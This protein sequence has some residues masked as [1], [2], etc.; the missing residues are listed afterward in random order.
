[1]T[2]VITHSARAA[3]AP[4]DEQP[5]RPDR[6]VDVGEFGSF[7]AE[8]TIMAGRPERRPVSQGERSPAE[9]AP[10]E[11]A[12]AQA[13][14]TEHA[15]PSTGAHQTLS[16]QHSLLSHVRA[17]LHLQPAGGAPRAD[18]AM[19]RTESLEAEP[20][21]ER[22][23]DRRG[24][25]RAERPVPASDGQ[26]A[27]LSIC[28][29]T[30]AMIG[31]CPDAAQPAP[32]DDAPDTPS[33][34]AGALPDPAAG[35]VSKSQE[36]PYPAAKVVLCETHFAPVAPR[37]STPEAFARELQRSAAEPATQGAAPEDNAPEVPASENA[38]PEDAAPAGPAPARDVPRN[39]P[40]RP[41]MSAPPISAP[42]TL[43]VSAEAADAR[44]PA[45]ETPVV[46]PRRHETRPAWPSID[47][48]FDKALEKLASRVAVLPADQATSPAPILTMPTPGTVPGSGV[49]APPASQLVTAIAQVVRTD[50]PAEPQAALMRG[51]VRIL[52]IQL[53]PVELGLVTVRLRTGRN[54]L[55][56]HVN[57]ARQE[58][59]RLLQQDHLTLLA[60]LIDQD[61]GPV[62]LTI[63][64]AGSPAALTGRD[65]FPPDER[66]QSAQ[67]DA[68]RRQPA[69]SDQRKK[70]QQSENAPYYAADGGAA[71]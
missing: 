46:E 49:T 19:E 63:S 64:Q 3:T 10:A 58:T 28:S 37:S 15:T 62:E 31:E 13:E 33:P 18:S 42:R 6:A 35:E 29:L 26:A 65:A 22:V 68:D 8:F 61:T 24:E 60:G 38:A 70:R 66:D 54:G 4:S 16:N 5:T 7:L 17:W 20:P 9:A 36:G 45:I 59:A 55:E 14:G 34:P 12:A 71:D 48:R 56:I 27:M 39:D 52:E 57:A 11:P 1:M 41:L 40:R 30:P 21:F 32:V 69:D 50:M 2:P 43:A 23:D 25:P 53:H 44:S 47:K 51:P 67:G